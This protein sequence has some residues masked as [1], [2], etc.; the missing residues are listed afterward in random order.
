MGFLIYGPPGTGKTKTICEMV[1]QL[2]NDPKFKGSILL[3]APSNPATDTLGLRLRAHLG[4]ETMLRLNA[5]S[6]TFAEVPQELLPYC[7]VEDDIF[8]IPPLPILMAYK[9]VITTCRDADALVQ[10]RVTNRD[11]ISVQKRLVTTIHPDQPR[12][13]DTAATLHWAALIVD[14]AAQA[15][16]PETLIP[17][18][19][20]A[21]HTSYTCSSNPILAM[22]GDEHQLNART[23]HRSTTLHVSLF[24][25]LSKHPIYASSR[26][27]HR[28]FR[29]TAPIIQPPFVNLI[30]N[31]R[32]HRAILAVP[33][34]LFYANSLI[35]ESNDTDTLQ[36]WSGWRGRPW[37]VMFACNGGVDDCEDIRTVGG[38][39][40]NK[41]EAGKAIAYTRSLLAEK[42]ILE[43]SEICIMS[44][45]RAQVSLLRKYARDSKLWGV[46]IGPMEAFQGL[47]SRFVII[48]TTRARQR[49]LGE[50]KLRGNGIINEAKKFN[51]AITRAKQ[52]L[53]VLGNPWVLAID[54]C[55]LAFMAFCRRNSL[56]SEDDGE[57]DARMH[58]LE[59]AK[60]NDW[61]PAQV[62][63]NSDV[64]DEPLIS[65]FEA[66]LVYK[67]RNK[68]GGSQAVRRFMN[69]SESLEEALWRTGLEAEEIL[70]SMET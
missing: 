38:G 51:V 24:E 61:S 16:E 34:A 37:P 41:R 4:P 28:S 20:V 54:P 46:N 23:Y 7:F 14:E 19:V 42:V 29:G 22:A 63:A 48:C 15:T 11:L 10:A 59:E 65:G 35:A 52:G 57:E 32:S 27:A 60:V 21:P 47:E 67:E 53:V 55:W 17:L 66:A 26:F 12:P 44:P 1:L 2:A 50:D 39:W 25:R 8:S 36:T 6:R 45:F 33:S 69:G 43:Q 70:E 31:Y 62:F 49:F 13:A 9:V 40:Y 56:W 68:E 64:Q 5:Y 30:R 58:G 18:T 3:C